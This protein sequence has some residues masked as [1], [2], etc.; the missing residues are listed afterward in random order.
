MTDNQSDEIGSYLK[1]KIL[2]TTPPEQN[3]ATH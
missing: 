2:M 1:M 3:S